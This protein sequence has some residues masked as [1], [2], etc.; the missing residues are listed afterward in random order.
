[1][2]N[3]CH[4]WVE[5]EQTEDESIGNC[6]FVKSYNQLQSI[7]MSLNI[8]VA[9]ILVVFIILLVGTSLGVLPAIFS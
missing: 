6:V 3:K 9:I 5:K 1:M 4:L 2:G 8:V 7:D